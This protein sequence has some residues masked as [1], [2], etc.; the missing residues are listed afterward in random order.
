MA[1]KNSERA[2]YEA[3]LARV[4]VHCLTARNAASA[5]G[6]EGAD[7]DL[8]SIMLAVKGLMQDS[9]HGKGGRLERG[10]QISLPTPAGGERSISSPY[11]RLNAHSS[12]D[13]APTSGDTHP[14]VEPWQD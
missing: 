4:F 10:V 3:A 14:E 9:V 2:R 13:I 5:M 11:R 8:C 12:G 1:A 7:A 6:M